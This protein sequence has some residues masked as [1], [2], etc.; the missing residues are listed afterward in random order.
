[1]PDKPLFDEEGCLILMDDKGNEVLRI[2]D[3]DEEEDGKETTVVAT[4]NIQVGC[5]VP[6]IIKNKECELRWER[7]VPG[8]DGSQS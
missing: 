7:R 2:C 4:H 6:I 5:G 8:R 1:M 3:D